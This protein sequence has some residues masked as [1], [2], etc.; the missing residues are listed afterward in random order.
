MAAQAIGE[1]GTQ[2]TM[3]TKHAGGVGSAGGDIV[4]G[5]PRVEEIFE[6][7]HPKNPAIV[8]EVDGTILEIKEE[9]KET[10]IIVL[11][12]EGSKKKNAKSGSVNYSI[13]PTRSVLVKKGDQIFRGQI[14]TDGSVD[15]TQYQKLTNRA[16]VEDYVIKEA[17]AIYQL[18]GVAIARKH[19]EL[20]FA[21]CFLAVRLK[22]RD[23]RFRIGEI[24][25][26]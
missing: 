4:G 20:L 22:P 18:Q 12:D 21:K 24:V 1:P 23:T 9:P 7:R 5:L 3:R 15:L 26:M 17:N 19:I 14:L 10:I 11:V 16:D 2:L 6:R 13:P 8:S 25:S